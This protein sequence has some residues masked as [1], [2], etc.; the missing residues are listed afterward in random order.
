MPNLKQLLDELEIKTDDLDEGGKK[1]DIN[2]KDVK[3]DD[4]PEAQ[5]PIFKK[6]IDTTE[7]LT[8]EVAKR[9]LIINT[10]K[11]VKTLATEEKEK[12]KT[13][14][15]KVLGVLDKTDPYA[16][17][18]Q[19]LSDAIEGIKLDKQKNTD[20]EFKN[21]LISF[22]KENKDIVRYVTDMD[23]L[24]EQHPSLK[25]DIPKLYI[26]A[27]AVHERRTT[28]E[29]TKK[30][31]LQKDPNRF[32]TESSGMSGRNVT[33]LSNAKS[34]QEAFEMVEKSAINK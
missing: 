2:L 26:L 29:K 11:D 1:D 10:L 4:I 28:Q 33:E 17:V 12:P 23:N 19:K 16:P 20:E 18:F 5:R 34:I 6:L 30:E 25:A 24:I 7:S 3:L 31:D 9:D 27:K 14:E 22:A 8:N 32:R 15:E 21:N 13:E